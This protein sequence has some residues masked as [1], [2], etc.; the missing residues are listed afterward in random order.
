[1]LNLNNL[2]LP[3]RNHG[4]N[5]YITTLEMDHIKMKG[6]VQQCVKSEIDVLRK[7]AVN[8]LKIVIYLSLSMPYLK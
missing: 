4:N 5:L 8:V 3:W 1:M 7:Q 2:I 6:S